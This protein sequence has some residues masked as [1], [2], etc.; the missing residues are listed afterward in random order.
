MYLH[1]PFGTGQFNLTWWTLIGTP[2]DPQGLDFSNGNSDNNG[3]ENV[4]SN[5]GFG[6]YFLTFGSEVML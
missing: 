3:L 5:H 6:F 2:L 1:T 4:L